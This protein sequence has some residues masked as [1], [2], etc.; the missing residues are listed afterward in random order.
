MQNGLCRLPIF[1]MESPYKWT[2]A[3]LTLQGSVTE[4][5]TGRGGK[6]TEADFSISKSWS[7]SKSGGCFG[8]HSPLPIIGQNPETTEGKFSLPMKECCCPWSLTSL[9]YTYLNDVIGSMSQSLRY[10][11][12]EDEWQTWTSTTDIVA[13]PTTFSMETFF[14]AKPEYGLVPTYAPIVVCTGGV[15]SYWEWNDQTQEMEEVVFDQRPTCGYR[16]SPSAGAATYGHEEPFGSVFF[17]AIMMSYSQGFVM[18]DID[19]DADLTISGPCLF[20]TYSSGLYGANGSTSIQDGSGGYGNYGSGTYT[21]S[22]ETITIDGEGSW[23][24]TLSI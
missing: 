24:F 17:A 18:P 12:E 2:Q 9:A 7:R 20:A 16:L 15:V 14:H 22:D 6:T 4:T 1:S 10:M 19:P 23:S 21:S 8:V 5:D 13:N 11:D 3:S